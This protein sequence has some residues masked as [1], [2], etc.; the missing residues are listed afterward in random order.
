MALYELMPN[1][2]YFFLTRYIGRASNAKTTV[3]NN[4]E[5]KVKRTYSL[6]EYTCYQQKD[7]QGE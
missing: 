1:G 6:Y 7:Q 3:K 4:Y 2:K 5:T